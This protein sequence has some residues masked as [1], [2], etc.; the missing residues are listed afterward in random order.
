MKIHVLIIDDDEDELMFIVKAFEYLD[1]PFKC[2]WA[3]NGEQGLRQLAYITPDL[4]FIDYNMPGMNG[5]QCLEAIK[6][7]AS[8]KFI[9][10]VLHSSLMDQLIRLKG[11][12][13]GATTCIRKP[14]SI[15]EL[16]NFLSMFLHE[17]A[18]IKHDNSEK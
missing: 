8:C 18:I 4:I 3:K 16:I 2:T 5:L 6:K 17:H 1:F 15:N 7:M 10:V 9:P 11:L 12:D 13:L 14:D